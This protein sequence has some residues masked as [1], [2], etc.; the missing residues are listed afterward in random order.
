MIQKSTY[1]E[2]VVA[3]LKD[4]ILNGDM[5]PGQRIKESLVAA[6]L[7]ISRAPVREALLQLMREGIVVSRPQVG[8]SVVSLTAKQILDSYVLG[9]V[10]EGF[11]L[12]QTTHLFTEADYA[13]LAGIVAKMGEI[14]AGS[15]DLSEMTR[16]DHEFHNAMFSK[17]D[18]ELLVEFSL[19]SSRGVTHFLLSHHLKALYPPEA[20]YQRHKAL[21]DVLKA[22]DGPTIERYMR[23]HYRETGELMA[24]YGSD[25]FTEEDAG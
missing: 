12:A 1:A 17:V 19:R 6:E 9:G 18:S 20:I 22:G 14:A 15:R 5:K 11:A 3:Y 8:K 10:L 4:K 21:L 23:D 24:R 25:V 7:E 2:Q 16:L 13:H